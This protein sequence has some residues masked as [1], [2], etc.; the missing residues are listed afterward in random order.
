MLELPPFDR[1]GSKTAIR[2]GILGG[3][4]QYTQAVEALEQALYTTGSLAY[5]SSVARVF[6]WLSAIRANYARQFSNR[7][8]VVISVDS[9]ALMVD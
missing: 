8:V 9:D 1:F 5:K 7:S 6:V 3:I 2:R 4:Q